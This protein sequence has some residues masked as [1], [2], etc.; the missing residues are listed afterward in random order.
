MPTTQFRRWCFT[1]NNPTREDGVRVVEL[2]SDDRVDCLCVGEETAPS[3]G[4]RHYQGYVEF[5]AKR[6]LAGAKK[7]LGLSLSVHLEP[8]VADR[9]TNFEY[10]KKGGNI[11][12]EKGGESRGPGY[13][14][15]I[16]GA[17]KLIESGGSIR[18]IA[19]SNFG[20]FLKFGNALSRYAL[21]VARPRDFRTQ[22]IWIYGRP[23]TGKS[24]W[25]AESN[26]G[27]GPR[28]TFW[29]S[30]LSGRWWDGYGSE[31]F[32]CIDDFDGTM[33]RTFLLRLLDRYP[34]K[35]PFKGGFTEFR[36]RV[37]FIT[38]Q[39][40]PAE[41]YEE[42]NKAEIDAIMRRIDELYCSDDE[43]WQENPKLVSHN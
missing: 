43:A 17:K 8:A 9:G 5:T 23:G 37:V 41:Y 34:L 42:A 32:V 3:T 29:L 1:L 12:A 2:A 35:V 27:L 26:C 22:C 36:S 4:T 20:L 30:D 39:R 6:T 33:P 28:D 14:T 11:V 31:P 10:C 21:L 16:E 15:D 13:R 38:S 24:R 40:P 7:L 19:E 18:D 25:I